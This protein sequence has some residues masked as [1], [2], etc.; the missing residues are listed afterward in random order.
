MFAVAVRRDARGVVFTL[1]GELD[2]D[3]VV[4]L[5]DA[6]ERELGRR[7][8]G[9]VVVDCAALSFCDSSGVSALIR[10]ARQLT[11]RDRE[12]R[13]AAVPASVSRLFSLT[14]LDQLFAVH[15]DVAE[16]LAGVAAGRGM[17]V[18]GGSDEPVRPSEGESA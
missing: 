13:L 16:A 12:L 1:R 2:F 17:V 18:A 4:Q 15:R 10:L 8:A 11:A 3:S 7:D 9:P 5:H 6:A 14:G